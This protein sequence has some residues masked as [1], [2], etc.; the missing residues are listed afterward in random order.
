LVGRFVGYRAPEPIE[1]VFLRVAFSHL[2][3]DED[4]VAP[5]EFD[6]LRAGVDEL[7]VAVERLA[8]VSTS[9]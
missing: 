9:L 3:N 7:R 5:S 2:W 6:Q 8:A 1:R 4:R